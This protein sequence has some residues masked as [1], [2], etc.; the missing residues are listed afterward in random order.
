IESVGMAIRAREP[1]IGHVYFRNHP[2][3][4]QIHVCQHGSKWERDHLL[5]R[6]YLRAHP[7]EAAAYERLKRAAASEYGDDRLAYT[8]AKGTFIERVLAAAEHWARGTGWQ[9]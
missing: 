5:F 1:D 4:L 2:R 6:D 8:E 9:P 3:S 7:V